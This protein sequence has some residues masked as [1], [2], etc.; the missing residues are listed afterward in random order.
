MSNVAVLAQQLQDKQ[1]GVRAQAAQQ[2][3]QCGDEASGAAV[4]LVEACGDEESVSQWA[5]AALEQSGPPPA[6]AVE[7]LCGLATHTHELVAYWAVTLLGRLGSDG[8]AA[9]GVLA[10]VLATSS[11]VAVRQRAAWAL[12]QIGSRASATVAA[13]ERAKSDL[14]PRLA[15]LAA[16]ALARLH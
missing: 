10:S 5:V 1:V 11:H 2:L 7:Q 12:G 15:R 8:A 13:L 4:A 14:D 9:A 16:Q 6:A 3:G